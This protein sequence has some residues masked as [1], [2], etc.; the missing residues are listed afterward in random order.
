MHQELIP[1]LMLQL[2]HQNTFADLCN[3]RAEGRENCNKRRKDSL[4][5]QG[6]GVA[7]LQ[8]RKKTDVSQN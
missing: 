4:P 2:S 3:L 1:H 5:A 8:R 7:P 6:G